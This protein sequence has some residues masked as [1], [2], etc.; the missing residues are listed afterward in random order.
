MDFQSFIENKM[1]L[2]TAVMGLQ[3]SSQ[4][5]FTY[6]ISKNIVHP[7]NDPIAFDSSDYSDCS[8]VD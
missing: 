8:G 2:T 7:E 6:K 4:A 5:L 3:T 1:M